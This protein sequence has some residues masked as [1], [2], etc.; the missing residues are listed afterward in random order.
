MIKNIFFKIKQI[1]T[2]HLNAHGGNYK[3]MTEGSLVNRSVE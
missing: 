2:V 1:R 3:N